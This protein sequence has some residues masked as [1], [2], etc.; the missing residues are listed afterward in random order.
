MLAASLGEV[1]ACLIRV[2]VEIIKQRRQTFSGVRSMF[3][4]IYTIKV[5]NLKVWDKICEY[6]DIHQILCQEMAKFQH[7]VMRFEVGEG[8]L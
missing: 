6:L 1:A 8:I 3:I 4:T 7:K 2:P 5:K